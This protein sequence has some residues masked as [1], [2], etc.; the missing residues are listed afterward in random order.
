MLELEKA[1]EELFKNYENT[2]NFIVGSFYIYGTVVNKIQKLK[3][4]KYKR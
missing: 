1:I 3:I 4:K 2:A